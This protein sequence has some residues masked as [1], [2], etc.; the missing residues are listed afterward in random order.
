MIRQ[1][2]KYHTCKNAIEIQKESNLLKKKKKKKKQKKKKK[3][4]P[5][6]I[7][8]KKEADAVK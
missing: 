7:Y 5:K 4:I 8:F 6:T 2:L 3:K 1:R